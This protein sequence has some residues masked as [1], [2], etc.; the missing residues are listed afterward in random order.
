LDDAIELT[1][2]TESPTV[3]DAGMLSVAITLGADSTLLLLLVSF[4]W[5]NARSWRL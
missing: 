3:I 4:A 2:G 5:R 1:L